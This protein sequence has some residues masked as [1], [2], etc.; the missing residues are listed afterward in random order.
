MNESYAILG[1]G[2]FWCLDAVYRKF[3]GVLDVVSGYAGGS[4]EDANYKAV[5]TG[6][7]GH[8]EVVKIIFDSDVISYKTLLD[9]FWKCHDP[10]SIDKQGNDAG[11]QYRSVIFYVNNEQ[12]ETASQAKEEIQKSMSSPV[13]TDVRPLENFYEAEMYHQNYF[14]KNPGNPYCYYVIKPKLETVKKYHF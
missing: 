8:I 3:N 13:V 4:A 5:C 9:I 1:G 7:T 11:P 6:T 14:E 2:C 12:K 10:T